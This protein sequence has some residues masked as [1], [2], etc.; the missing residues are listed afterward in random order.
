MNVGFA[1]GPLAGPAIYSSFQPPLPPPSAC[2]DGSC[3]VCNTTTGVEITYDP[4][5]YVGYSKTLLVLSG[6]MLIGIPAML[7]AGANL[8][9]KQIS[10]SA[11]GAT[12]LTP[13]L[14]PR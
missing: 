10:V 14:R 13:S 6:V 9:A 5:T 11:V 2:A 3:L 8:T 7:H 1:V 12:A 4:A